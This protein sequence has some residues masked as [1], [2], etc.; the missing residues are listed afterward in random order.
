MVAGIAHELNNP[1]TSIVSLAELLVEEDLPDEINADFQ[2]IYK[3]TMRAARIVRKLLTFSRRRSA[4]R[5]PVQVNEVVHDVLN[6]R[7]YEH[8]VNNIRVE[9]HLAPDLPEVAVDNHEI[10]QVFLNIILNAES[11]MIEAHSSG[12]LTI[13]SEQVGGV[14]RVSFADDGP[15]IP[16]EN[17][18]RV[19]D[20]FFTTK[21]PGEGTGLGLSIC[22]GIVKEHGGKVFA[23]SRVGKGATLVVELPLLGS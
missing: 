7:A 13:A 20:P 9:S 17:L 14:V 10:Q 19:F 22:R 6:L 23:K 4:G 2:D 1:L 21:E 11:A 12:V 15:G 18:S 16:E 3:E 8:R 5:L